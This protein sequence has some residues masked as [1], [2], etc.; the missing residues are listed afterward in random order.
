M[1]RQDTPLVSVVVAAYQQPAF[2]NLALRSISAQTYPAIE[3]VVVDDAS[4]P[5]HTS[6]YGLPP[7]ARLIVHEQRSG[8]AAVTR[9]TGIAVCRGEYVAFL[10]QDDLWVPEKLS[11]QVARMQERPDARLIFGHFRRI[12]AAGNPSA[13]LTA[14]P[15]LRR[16][17]LRQ[18]I[19]RNFIQ[20][21]SQVLISRATLREIGFFDPT[22][23]G[24]ADWDLW[25]RAVAAGPIIADPRVMTM[26]RQHDQQWSRDRIMVRQGGVRVMEKTAGWIA[27]VRPDLRWQVRRRWARWLREVARAQFRSQQRA[28]RAEASRTLRRGLALWPLDVQGWSVGVCGLLHLPCPI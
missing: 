12:D 8:I 20:C 11:W 18:I 15:K 16:D 21:P 27:S 17:P 9:N 1:V 26:Y 23:R 19:R 14:A 25:I 24:S 7:S 13:R 3:I 5:E 4:G 10:D 6:R 2:L 28:E 22:I